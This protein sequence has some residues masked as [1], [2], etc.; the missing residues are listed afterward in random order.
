MSMPNREPNAIATRPAR[1]EAP[2]FW[3]VD[4]RCLWTVSAEIERR[5]AEVRKPFA[6]REVGLNAR[7]E[8]RPRLE[9]P[10]SAWQSSPAKRSV[11]VYISGAFR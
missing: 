2:V 8:K 1:V 4:T 7:S 5:A 6:L 3:N 11:T 10:S 9:A